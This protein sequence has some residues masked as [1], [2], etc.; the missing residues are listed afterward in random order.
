MN[1]NSYP[2]TVIFFM[3]IVLDGFALGGCHTLWWELL[4]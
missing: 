1:H 2:I 3:R 4:L